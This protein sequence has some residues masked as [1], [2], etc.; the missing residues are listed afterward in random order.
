MSS[1]TARDIMRQPVVSIP[2]A[3]SVAEAVR[4]M[5]SRRISSLIV[6]PRYA[7]DPFGI[8]TKA[9][10]VAKVVAAG[11]DAQRLH[12]SDVMT[13][14]VHTVAPDC[15]MRDCAALMMLYRV[16]RLPVCGDGGEPIG[17][18]SDSD[19]FG[20]LLRIDS[21]PAPSFLL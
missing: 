8:I 11:K 17:I 14:P 1:V 15:T 19:V 13:Q 6:L 7:G 20:A 2:A 16:R 5:Q 10:V 18:V 9:D 4:R 12:V 21:Q 3:E